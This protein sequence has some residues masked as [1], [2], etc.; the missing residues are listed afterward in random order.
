[1]ACQFSRPC[2]PRKRRGRAGT[3]RGIMS[4]F[5]DAVFNEYSSELE[6]NLPELFVFVPLTF[7]QINQFA[8]LAASV[9]ERCATQGKNAELAQ[10]R[11]DLVR[12]NAR[13]AFLLRAA[14]SDQRSIADLTV[15]VSA[16][17]YVIRLQ[18]VQLMQALSC[19]DLVLEQ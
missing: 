10:L 5:Y 14:E 17:D 12:A 6:K 19:M 3:E 15:T 1:M 13:I 2:N 8:M 4:E 9:A 7:M 11:A 18:A 16:R